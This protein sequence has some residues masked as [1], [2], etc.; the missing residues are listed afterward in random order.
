MKEQIELS[1]KK[2]V[3]LAKR[4]AKHFGI[5]HEEAVDSVYKE[6][7]LVERLLMQDKKIKAISQEV[8]TKMS[9][10]SRIADATA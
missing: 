3:K 7:E 10:Y 4:I 2:L 9:Q 1:E 6:W 8:I 5:S